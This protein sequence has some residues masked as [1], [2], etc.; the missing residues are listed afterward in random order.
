MRNVALD[1]GAQK[2]AYCEVKDREVVTR[3]TTRGLSALLPL[4]GPNAPKAVV[5][6]EAC[7]EAWHISAKLKE[8]G[9]DVAL[10]D[11]TRVRRIGVGS[12][13]R[14]TDRLDA[15]ALARALEA[16]H[17]PIAHMLSP[18]RQ[19][20]R[21]QIGVRHA[22]VET[23]AQYVT[24][25]RHLA[26][27]HG[28]HLP[29]CTAGY[30]TVKMRA[31]HLGEAVRELVTPL[32]ATIEQLDT[33]IRTADAKLVHLCDQEPLLKV[34]MTAPGVGLIVAA[35][36]VSV[37]DDA[38]RFENAH[39]VEAYLGLV[40]SE[41][42]SGSQRR[43]GSITKQGNRYAR[44]ML[45]EAAHSIL[46]MRGS[47]DPLKR[48]ADAVAQR[49]SRNIAAVALARRLTGVLWAMWKSDRVYD[50]AMLGAASARGLECAAQDAA[51]RAQA[52]KRVGE[53]LQRR[54]RRTTKI[55]ED[56]MG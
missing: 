4:L 14:K 26:R 50:P 5:A 22:L 19:K 24:T 41:N 31:Q 42:S 30:F 16:G 21:M 54:V 43:L 53:K 18:E 1:V 28:V 7:R 55:T 36:F 32:L 44:A 46:R 38:R 25:I 13:G 51:L 48:W 15:E 20:L 9:H 2:I 33:H 6:I 52:F 10:V 47:E 27:T 8:W 17:L 35:T 45:L 23:R 3:T 39:Q 34:L 56:A 12:H 40:P 37:I 49:R 29:S 11:T